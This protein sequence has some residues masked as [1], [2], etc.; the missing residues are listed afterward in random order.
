MTKSYNDSEDSA[1]AG[2][3]YSLLSFK[4]MST[5]SRI[6]L[7]NGIPPKALRVASG[8]QQAQGWQAVV[9]PR[10][11][12][13]SPL[14]WPGHS[15]SYHQMSSVEYIMWEDGKR[16]NYITQ[17]VNPIARNTAGLIGRKDPSG[18]LRYLDLDILM[19]LSYEYTRTGQPRITTS[20][21]LLLHM[22]G[23]SNLDTAPFREFRASVQRM[24]AT[25]IVTTDK[26]APPDTMAPWRLVALNA[27]S[28]GEQGRLGLLDAALS[29]E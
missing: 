3:D 17:T 13:L 29:S 1:L 21:R 5:S 25:T 11:V 28:A 10:E 19:A 20:Q 4:P 24:A 9:T 23:Y 12:L 27:M 2:V 7:P 8:R 6:A 15:A 18:L 26:G 14:F 22:M 16:A